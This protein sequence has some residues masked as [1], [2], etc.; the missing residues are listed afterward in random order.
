[1]KLSRLKSK[2]VKIKMP[3]KILFQLNREIKVTQKRK[4][5][6]K[7]SSLRIKYS[8]NAIFCFPGTSDVNLATRFLFSGRG[9]P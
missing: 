9:E 4:K 5:K 8:K 6:R 3:L 1:M 2:I 7:N